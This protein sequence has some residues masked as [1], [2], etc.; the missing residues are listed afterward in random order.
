MIINKISIKPSAVA[1]VLGA[2]ALFLVFASISG[3]MAKYFLG[4]DY[5]K[6]LVPLFFLD[7]ER[8]I[9]TFFSMLL[10]LAITLLLAIITTLKHKQKSPYRSRWAILTFGFFFMSFDEAFQVHEKFILPMRALLGNENLG[11]FYHAWVVIGIA[12]VLFAGMF[13]FR[14]LLRLPTKTRLYFLLAASLFIGGAIGVELLGGRYAELYGHQNLGYSMIVT[15]EESLEIGGL[16]VFI[17]A[18]LK[19]IADNYK[20]VRFRRNGDYGDTADLNQ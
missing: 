6:G 19:Y 7:E 3:Q 10:M 17:W 14:F 15:A 8:N 2:V 5:V 16:I 20:E 11:I 13:F 12:I 1:R 4:Y 9:P 18:L